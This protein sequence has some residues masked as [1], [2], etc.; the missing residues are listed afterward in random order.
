MSAET[1]T[2][3]SK[4]GCLRHTE[5]SVRSISNQYLCL[6]PPLKSNWITTRRLP[7][8]STH[9][10]RRNPPKQDNGIEFVRPRIAEGPARSPFAEL[11]D[12]RLQFAAGR[13]QAVFGPLAPRRDAP[14]QHASSFQPPQSL[15]KQ[16]AGHVRKTALQL[17][18]VI[19]VGKKLADNEHCPA[20]G[21]DFRR[22]RH[23][24]I[25]AVK[26]HN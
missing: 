11:V 16:R 4:P 21:K 17:I 1:I 5:T 18:E 2:S 23:R 20:V 10:P 13:C 22:S 8:T 7:M 3:M 6:G 9:T 26:V 15:H 25:L 14:L 19:N 12:D 24:T